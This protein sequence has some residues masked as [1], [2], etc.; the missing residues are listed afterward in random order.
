MS[1]QQ[2]NNLPPLGSSSSGS[3]SPA[4]E[5]MRRYRQRRRNGLR[6]LTIQLRETEIDA[7]VRRGFLKPDEPNELSALRESF[8]AYLDRTLGSKA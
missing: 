8:Y 5:R 2:M 3:S 7:L 4:A 1:K 6:C